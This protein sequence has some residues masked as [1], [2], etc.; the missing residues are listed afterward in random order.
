[1]ISRFCQ[2]SS[3]RD[4]WDAE[5][6]IKICRWAHRK[7]REKLIDRKG[8]L[9]AEACIC[10]WECIVHN[11][12]RREWFALL[13]PPVSPRL[14][15]VLCRVLFCPIMLDIFFLNNAILVYEA[16]VSDENRV[17]TSTIIVQWM[18]RLRNECSFRL[19]LQTKLKLV[20]GV[21]LE[22]KVLWNSII[23]SWK[24]M[25]FFFRLLWCCLLT[26]LYIRVLYIIQPASVGRREGWIVASMS[27]FKKKNHRD[28]ADRKTGITS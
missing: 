24:C 4:N 2:R 8:Q 5:K 25:V 3:K 12:E 19:L 28:I 1:M 21:Y 15:E 16:E 6:C 22:F 11:W 23:L 18:C 27:E 13:F 20:F 7:E 9:R 17:Y 10:T 14:C 26:N